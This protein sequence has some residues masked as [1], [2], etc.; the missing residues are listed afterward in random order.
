MDSMYEILMALPLFHGVS[1]AKLSEVIGSTKFHF[2]K[3]LDG[4]LHSY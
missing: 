4:A 2:L 1:Y 3:Y